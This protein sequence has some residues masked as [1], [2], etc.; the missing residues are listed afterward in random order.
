MLLVGSLTLYLWLER[1]LLPRP[2]TRAFFGLSNL[3]W[4]KKA[5]GYFYATR[6]DLYLKPATWKWV[7][8]L[9]ADKENGDPYHGKVIVKNDAAKIITINQSIERDLEHI[10]PY[11]VARS[12]ILNHPLPS[13]G[14]MECPCRAQTHNSCPR[15]VCLVVGEPFVSFIVEH[16]PSKARRLTVDEALQ[17]LEEEEERGHIH[18]AWF[19]EVMHN[20]FYTICNCCSCCCL[21]MASHNRG[22]PRISHS[23]YRPVVTTDTCMGCATC[24]G[25]C[26]FG[27]LVM[28][29]IIPV[30]NKEKC[31]GCGVCLSHCPTQSLQLDMVPEKGIPLDITKLLVE[32]GW[33]PVANS[34]NVSD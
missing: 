16:S 26:P 1:S 32:D 7:L 14:V 3:P 15:D 33:Q 30:I 18:T 11:P 6:P 24:V 21:G 22:V 19:K 29:D 20:R 28:D 25:I 4:L 9:A 5:E 31:M 27:A 12:L 13:V 34:A 2:S 8:K 10:L 23:G 17:I